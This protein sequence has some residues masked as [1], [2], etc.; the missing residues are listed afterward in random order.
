MMEAS[1]MKKQRDAEY[2]TW[3]FMVEEELAL[4]QA[5]TEFYENENK[6]GQ[7]RK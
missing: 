4:A 1:F 6:I 2:Q 5:I 7:S 3:Y